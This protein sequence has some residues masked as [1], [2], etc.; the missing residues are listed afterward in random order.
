MVMRERMRLKGG[1]IKNERKDM[2]SEKERK[3]R[4]CCVERRAHI[5]DITWQVWSTIDE[6]L[7]KGLKFDPGDFDLHQGRV[8]ISIYH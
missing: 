3:R 6:C 4:H 8:A 1:L 2:Y 7:L 5:S